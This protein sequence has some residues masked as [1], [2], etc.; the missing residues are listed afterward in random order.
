M[1]IDQNLVCKQLPSKSVKDGSIGVFS[2][3]MKRI[4]GLTLKN[5]RQRR[6][7]SQLELGF[8]ANVT[9]RPI[10]FLETGR[11]QPSRPMLLQLSEALAVPRQQRNMLLHAAG[12]A[13][14]YRAH[15]LASA[16]MGQVCAAMTWALERHDPY[17]A[18]AL[19]RHWTLVALNVSGKMLL[20]AATLSVGDNLLEALVNRGPLWDSIENQDEVLAYVVSRLKIESKHIGGDRFLD[21]S[22]A[23]LST[24]ISK[25]AAAERETFNAVVPTR[26]R[27][28]AKTL[29][30]F[31][32]IAQ[33][34]TAE[35]IALA[36]LKIEFLFPAGDKTRSTLEDMAKLIGT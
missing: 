16:D 27:F 9:A 28:G 8:S 21:A 13:D 35:D 10:A 36:D 25:D 3:G 6:R 11:S 5:W 31:A 29:S 34:G 30:L 24:R 18:I 1:E 19:D 17:P 32:T 33:F 12:F 4:F 26:Y 7:M 14:I 15:P 20:G 22:I 23:K 2:Q